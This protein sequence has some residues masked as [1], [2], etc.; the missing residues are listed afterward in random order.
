VFLTTEL[1]GGRFVEAAWLVCGLSTG[2][3][4]AGEVRKDSAKEAQ[5]PV[6][7]RRDVTACAVPRRRLRSVLEILRSCDAGPFRVRFRLSR[8]DVIA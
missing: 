8:S 2:G 6:A 5:G 4:A 3:S 1:S 7:A